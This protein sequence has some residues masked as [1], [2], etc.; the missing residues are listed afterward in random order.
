MPHG[1]GAKIKLNGV[2][3]NLN[4]CYSIKLNGVK[5]NL[6]ISEKNLCYSIK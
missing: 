2:K 4:I 3:D 5:D 1:P 6:N